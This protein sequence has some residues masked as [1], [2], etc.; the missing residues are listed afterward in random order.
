[1]SVLRKKHPPA[2]VIQTTP[3]QKMHIFLGGNL[4][5]AGRHWPQPM[6]LGCRVPAFMGTTFWGGGM[7]NWTY[8]I[9]RTRPRQIVS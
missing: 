7:A 4:L 3:A 6:V 1:M 5:Q 9:T 2:G 8:R